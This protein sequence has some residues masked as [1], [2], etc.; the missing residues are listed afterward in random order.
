VVGW[1]LG[2]N[3][4]FEL[5]SRAVARAGGGRRDRARCTRVTGL[6]RLLQNNVVRTDAPD[7]VTLLVTV[8]VLM[9]AALA[10]SI[11]PTLRAT[12]LNPTTALRIH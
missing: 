6:G 10:A 3:D 5:A 11:V 1:G 7:L 4:H 2:D 12:H 9:T 8:A